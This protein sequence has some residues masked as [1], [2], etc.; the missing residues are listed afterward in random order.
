M[1]HWEHYAAFWVCEKA[2]FRGG[3]FGGDSGRLGPSGAA[4]RAPRISP[5]E[6]HTFTID[7]ATI[8]ITY[9]R[10]SMRGRRIFGALV[11][12]NKVWMPGADEATIFRPAP[13]CSSAISTWPLGSYSL[14]TLPSEKITMLIINK[15]TGQFHTYHPA[16]QDLVKL[17]MTAEHLPA[18]VEQ[19]TISAVPRPQGGGAVQL[20]WETTRF[21]VPFV[22]RATSASDKISA[23]MQFDLLDGLF[24]L[25][26]AAFIGLDVIR[27]VS[28][29]LHTP[30]MSLTN[31]ISAIAVVGAILLAGEQESQLSTVLGAIAV[32]AST[33]NIVSGFLITDR[34]LKMFKRREPAAEPAEGHKMID[35]LI[36][37][38]YLVATA[39]FIF[40]LKWMS[41]PATARR[42]VF[43]GVGGMALAIVGTL[44]HPLI[45]GYSWI[46]IP[47]V[48][49]ALAGIPFSWVPLT[50]VPQRTALSHAFGGLAAGL[51]G[52]AKYYLWAEQGQL[53]T[54]R[55]G[56]IALEV[57]LGYLTCTEAWIAAG[58]L[59]EVIP[60]R[61]ISYR[62]QNV[63]NFALLG[64]AIVMALC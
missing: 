27:R 33:T 19:L 58:K 64:A 3:G 52:T 30:L 23:R 11:P 57:I 29:L 16:N 62:G 12:Y 7:G 39:L 20:E 35:Q 31:A 15:M 6:E 45:I 41:D 9:G 2:F 17:P 36:Q 50:A 18:A 8:T 42:G 37:L 25:M 34:M 59:Q 26:L 1:F 63:I 38:V 4:R 24:V 21:S 10:P 55:M 22:V 14:Y 28:R 54:F 47:L 40:S 48:L 46:V 53:T 5:H 32:F 44:M 51:V 43:A 13:R 49:G 61:P 60:T 56:A